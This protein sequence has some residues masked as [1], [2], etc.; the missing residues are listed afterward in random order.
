MGE[1]I[2]VYGGNLRE[3]DLWEDPGVDGRLIVRWIFRKW[4]VWIW[5]G[6]GW[7][8]IDTGGGQL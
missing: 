8:R 7:H 3:K 6:L 4:D 1:K 5:T 2:G